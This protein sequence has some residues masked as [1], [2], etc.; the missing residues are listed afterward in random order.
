MEVDIQK[1]SLCTVTEDAQNI[2]FYIDGKLIDSTQGNF[3][4]P[5]STGRLNIGYIKTAFNS[6]YFKGIMDDLKIFN[7]AMTLMRSK[8]NL[9][10]F[11]MALEKILLTDLSE[12]LPFIDLMVI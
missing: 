6:I 3:A 2:R 4:F 7:Y 11:P 10:T 1:W 5:K 8:M 12:W 9:V